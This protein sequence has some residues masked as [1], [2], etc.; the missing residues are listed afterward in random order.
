MSARRTGPAGSRWAR[1]ATV[2]IALIVCTAALGVG[3]A[4]VG[5][6][7][8][9]WYNQPQPVATDTGSLLDAISCVSSSFCM[10]VGDIYAAPSD[11]PLA[12]RWNGKQWLVSP[13][14][15]QGSSVVSQLRAVSCRTSKFCMAVGQTSSSKGTSNYALRWNGSK[16]TKLPQ[17]LGGAT[18]YS[19]SCWS[20]SACIA[21]GWG[22]TTTGNFGAAQYWNGKSWKVMS[23]VT[24]SGGYLL[25]GVSCV[26][27]PS[28]ECVAAGTR[29][30]STGDQAYIDVWHNGKWVGKA[31][32]TTSGI[33]LEAV[34]CVTGKVCEAVGSGAA[35]F[36]E[37]W[38]GTKWSLQSTPSP[39]V[40][41][42]VLWGVS[43][44]GPSFCVAV[45][46]QLVPSPDPETPYFN[47]AVEVFTGGTWVSDEVPSPGVQSTLS[48]VSCASASACMAAGQEISTGQS[49]VL[50]SWRTNPT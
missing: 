38:N 23:K 30:V 49:I 31:Q 29:I 16:W 6:T 25:N 44:A 42:N 7:V 11:Q 45:G 36:A 4:D 19:V 8:P 22:A 12:E 37:R 15:S 3:S 40:T 14:P 18:L 41:Q 13:T 33:I 1:V 28:L 5:A 47:T 20:S 17:A 27:S 39:G 32:S 34:S 24:P 26:T 48:G 2:P 21:V 46:N 50:S 35:W 43:C 10:A 9:L